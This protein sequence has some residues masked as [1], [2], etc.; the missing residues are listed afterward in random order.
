MNPKNIR[1]IAI[2]AHVDHGK[3]TLVDE[4]LKAGGL[5]R[6]NQEVGDRMMDSMDLEREKGITIKAKNTS[7]HW[8]DNLINIVDT[9]GHADFGA[10]V[11]RVMKMVDGVLLLVDAYEGPQAQTRFVL[12]K[13][14]H[15]HLKPIVVINKVDREHADPVAV[16]DKVLELFLDLEADE[17]QFNA[18]FVYAS[19]KNGWADHSLDGPRK[20][21]SALFETIM[22][23]IDPPQV[24][25]GPF[26]MLVSNIDW[27]DYVGRVAVG[28]IISGEA[29]AG[30]RLQIIHK[31]G[32]RETAKIT[33]LFEYS[34]LQTADS[35]LAVAGN[36]VGLAGFEEVD[37]GETIVASAGQEALPFV[38][39]D[40][41][42]IQM[43]FAVNDG[44][45]AGKDG[46]KVTS[47]Q[48]RERLIRE[49]KTNISIQVD[50]EN[51]GARFMVSARGAMQIAVLVEQMR[52]EGF[53]VLVSRP[54]VIKQEVDGRQC[55]PF[56]NV[57]VDV[58]DDNV[59]GIMKN[60][61]SRKGQMTGMNAH[62]GRTTI[63]ANIPTRGLIGFE[64][65]LVN[66]TSGHGVMSHMF[67]SYKPLA[68]EIVSRQTG[69]LVSMDQGPSTGY[70]LMALEERGKLF[71]APGEETYVGMIVGEC[72]KRI[73]LPVNP[74]KGKQLTNFRASGSD[75]NIQL[76]PPI[77]FSLE[78]ALEY[79]E[80]DE[81]V[82][83]TPKTLRLRKRILDPHAR[84]RMEKSGKQ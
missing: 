67:D 28:R 40:P 17:D 55:E 26:R 30:E 60:L 12:M 39:I 18:P 65:D 42:T 45:F 77:K 63:E 23:R 29:N 49:T 61:A 58:P 51:D 48:I 57:W 69:T 84:K 38:E 74:T 1:N 7:V 6:A 76:A 62:M 64:F 79:I 19:A 31:D 20:D 52:R 13:A 46:K 66:M 35:H 4:M 78:R 82:E 56:E 2:I 54:R 10:E 83:A 71:V 32:K 53:E 16:H 59:G 11:E 27:N 36:I 44:P 3:T 15:Q 8:K 21:M 43:E 25:E 75:K 37:I 33:K 24:E 5:F 14:L 73:D 34:G 80:S 9:P 50:E 47:R 22:E 72:P 41:P 81:Y 68:G 70:A